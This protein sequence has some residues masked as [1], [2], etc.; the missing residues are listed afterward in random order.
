MKYLEQG[1]AHPVWSINAGSYYLEV[2]HGEKYSA[3]N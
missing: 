1:L 2:K 3:K